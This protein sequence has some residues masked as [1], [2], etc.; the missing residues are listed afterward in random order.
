MKK[1]LLFTFLIL[2][3]Y[4]FSQVVRPYAGITT[5]LHSDFSNSVFLGLNS[6]CE[7]KIINH[8]SI[9]IEISGIVGA[10]QDFNHKNENNVIYEEFTSSVTA[11]NYSIC[12]KI[13]LGNVN[14]SNSYFVLLPKFSI[15]N[16]EA[17]RTRT[18]YKDINTVLKTDTK[19]SKVWDNSIG[20]GIGYNFNLS[21]V[22]PDSICI[23]LQLQGV[24]LGKALNDV[25]TS[26]NRISTKWTFGLGINYYFNLKKNKSNS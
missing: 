17:H 4:T 18:T 11:I 8:L 23:I 2:S 6:G 3:S 13:N 26:K 25:R 10:L 24:E 7:F 1:I 21:D 22:S 5:Y 12:P 9:D 19:I 16:I 15:S 20:V 14:G